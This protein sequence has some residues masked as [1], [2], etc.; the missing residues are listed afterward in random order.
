MEEKRNTWKENAIEVGTYGYTKDKIDRQAALAAYYRPPG[1]VTT[2]M[3][4][5][6][7]EK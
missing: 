5:K 3:K 6:Q 4:K 2:G 1:L 7:Q